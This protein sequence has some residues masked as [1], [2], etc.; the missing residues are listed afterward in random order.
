MKIRIFGQNPNLWQPWH[1]ARR[2]DIY[3]VLLVPSRAKHPVKVHIWGG[4]TKEGQTGIC[5][6]EGIMDL[7]LFIEILEIM[8]VPFIEAKY[9]THHKFMQDNDPKHTSHHVQDFIRNQLVENSS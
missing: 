2:I 7:F 1:Y 6:F 4:I 5:V 8:L 3:V 9:P